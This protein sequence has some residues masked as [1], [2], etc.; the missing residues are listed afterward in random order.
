MVPSFQRR[1]DLIQGPGFFDVRSPL[2][3]QLTQPLPPTL[4]LP[5]LFAPKSQTPQ[6][7]LPDLA[8][9]DLPPAC[10]LLALPQVPPSKSAL[11]VSTISV[12]RQPPPAAALW[13]K[14]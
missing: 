10:C 14:Q 3:G 6:K 7:L 9:L 13:R 8:W 5:T 4:D 11:R 12:N 2:F 1:L